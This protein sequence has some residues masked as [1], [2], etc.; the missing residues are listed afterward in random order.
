MTSHSLVFF[1]WLTTGDMNCLFLSVGL[2][3]D[4]SILMLYCLCGNT[5]TTVPVPIH[6]LGLGPVWFWT[7]TGVPGANVSMRR[8]PLVSLSSVLV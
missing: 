5:A 6:L 4:P 8:V 3:F 2:E 1:H 7:L